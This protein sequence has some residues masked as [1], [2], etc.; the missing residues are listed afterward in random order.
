MFRV[1]IHELYFPIMSF[2]A[3]CL[4]VRLR[5]VFHL[6]YL[7]EEVAMPFHASDDM[8]LSPA[9]EKGVRAIQCN[10]ISSPGNAVCL[11]DT[12]DTDSGELLFRATQGATLSSRRV[13]ILRLE[14]ETVL[15][16]FR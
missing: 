16:E 9:E 6:C 8:E 4:D 14:F 10:T 13:P 5:D 2:T 7:S 12:K 1:G 11:T 15:F 3:F